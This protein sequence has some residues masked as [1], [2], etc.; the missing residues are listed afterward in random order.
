M[1]L[2]TST[3]TGSMN[4]LLKISIVILV[5]LRMTLL[6]GEPSLSKNQRKGQTNVDI[7]DG[8]FLIFLDKNAYGLND[9]DI[10][11][12]IC[13]IDEFPLKKFKKN[14]WFHITCLLLHDMGN[15][16]TFKASK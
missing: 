2:S 7:S 13:N 15:L 16:E 5:F 6:S 1:H 14:D 4:Y 8:C 3:A 9:K 11:C 12:L 10:H